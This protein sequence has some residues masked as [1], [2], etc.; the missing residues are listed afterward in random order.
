[1]NDSPTTS[2]FGRI[3]T[4]G[5]DQ[6]ATGKIARSMLNTVPI[7]LVGSMA[8]GLGLTGPI[9]SLDESGDK[10]KKPQA[11]PKPVLPAIETAGATVVEEAVVELAS[12]RAS[13]IAPSSYT[14]KKG[15]TVATI[16]GSFGLSTASVLALNGLSWKS[17]IFPGQK[18]SL[19]TAGSGAQPTR[20][21]SGAARSYTIKRGDTL[22]SIAG[23]H[24]VGTSALLAANGLGWSSIIYPGQK[25]TVPG[26][27]T[28]STAAPQKTATPAPSTSSA[29]GSKYTIKSG[30]TIGRIASA[31]GTSVSALLSANGLRITST[32]YAGKT[33]TIPGRGATSAPTTTPAATSATPRPA[34][35]SLSAEQER[36]A[37]AII[38]VGRQIGAN[39]RAIVIAL[40]AA[41]QE[42][43]LRNIDHGDRDS[44]GLFQQRPSTGWGTRAQL[45]DPTHA[46]KLFFGGAT[47]PNKGFTRG[48]LDIKGWS[49]MSLTSAAQA[50]QISGHPTAY[51]KWE[52]SAASWLAALG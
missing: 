52:S 45:L 10:V 9:S 19:T 40:A 5:D 18:L 39:D 30:D 12:T 14:V 49:S 23:A 20:A 22:S 33:L 46:T 1:M 27:S 37:R 4:A 11:A 13:V 36:N 6:R 3:D 17:T 51:A 7:M 24:G 48:L 38:S 16:A 28:P 21:S 43:S 44:V 47:N 31:T 26:G 42:S 29:T 41:A 8:L 34:G 2:A 50:V 25:L 32:I 15:D 35:T